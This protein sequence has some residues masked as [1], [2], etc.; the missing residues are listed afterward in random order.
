MPKLSISE[1]AYLLGVSTDRLKPWE[2]E[3]FLVPNCIVWEVTRMLGLFGENLKK[4][5]SIEKPK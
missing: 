2:K 3:Q 4:I 5:G 1:A